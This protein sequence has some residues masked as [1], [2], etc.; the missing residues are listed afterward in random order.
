MAGVDVECGTQ[1]VSK[2]TRKRRCRRSKAVALCERGGARARPPRAL[3][4]EPSE[5]TIRR[6]VSTLSRQNQCDLKLRRASPA[7]PFRPLNGSPS[8]S[9]RSGSESTMMHPFLCSALEARV[10]ALSVCVRACSAPETRDER[11]RAGSASLP[12]APT[13]AHPARTQNY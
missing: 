11:E 2:C 7:R 8:S 4:A 5:R 6:L 9:S 1:T 12:P 3:S 10:A 13:F